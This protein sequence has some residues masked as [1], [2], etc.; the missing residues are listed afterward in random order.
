MQNRGLDWDEAKKKIGF[1][2]SHWGIVQNEGTRQRDFIVGSIEKNEGGFLKFWIL[3][4][5]SV[6]NL[7][8]PERFY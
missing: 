4:I 5:L 8:E 1:Y 6:K 3:E 7:V 2:L